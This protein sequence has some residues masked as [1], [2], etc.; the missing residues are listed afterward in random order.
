MP[1]HCTEIIYEWRNR[2]Y[3]LGCLLDVLTA[4]APSDPYFHVMP[5]ADWKE[6]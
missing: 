5:G 4:M 1:L 2:L 6:P 3:S